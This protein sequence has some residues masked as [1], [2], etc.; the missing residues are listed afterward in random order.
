MAKK[1]ELKKVDLVC[2]ACGR[3]GCVEVH[4]PMAEALHARMPQYRAA[5]I[6]CAECSALRR[7]QDLWSVTLGKE[8]K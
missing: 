5:E 3:K 6:L 2:A 8:A 7:K 1:E 4:S